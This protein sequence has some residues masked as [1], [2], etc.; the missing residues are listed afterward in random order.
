M[1]AE[2]TTVHL[3]RSRFAAAVRKYETLDDAEQNHAAPIV[4]VRSSRI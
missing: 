4:A 1:H 2:P 3:T